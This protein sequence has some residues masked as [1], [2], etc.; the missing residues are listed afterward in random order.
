M[1]LISRGSPVQSGTPPPYFPGLRRAPARGCTLGST[2]LIAEG[3]S[4]NA[5]ANKLNLSINTVE[6]YR[7]E[8]MR[9]LDIHDVA[10][11]V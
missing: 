7:R 11:V 4:T 3:S 2:P 8:L 10:G 9:Q 1:G 6:T 5:I